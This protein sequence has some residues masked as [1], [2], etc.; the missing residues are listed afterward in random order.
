MVVFGC[1]C[2]GH[3]GRRAGRQNFWVCGNHGGASGDSSNMTRA[4]RSGLLS[5]REVGSGVPEKR[6]P[7]LMLLSIV[8]LFTHVCFSRRG[9][10]GTPRIEWGS[11]RDN[12]VTSQFQPGFLMFG[13][14]M[15][16]DATS[17]ALCRGLKHES[18]TTIAARAAENPANQ[19][20]RDHQ[21]AT[22]ILGRNLFAASSREVGSR[23]RGLFPHSA[24]CCALPW[25]SSSTDLPC[26]FFLVFALSKPSERRP[27]RWQ[28]RR[29]R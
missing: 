2:Q 18:R 14:V 20:P 1:G 25:T 15:D 3:A 27:T 21:G 19:N 12:L 29:T 24:L 7:P 6:V 16:P 28:P 13:G 10:A 17:G 11:R 4:W 9:S 8:N 5:A 22:S 23:E 26:P